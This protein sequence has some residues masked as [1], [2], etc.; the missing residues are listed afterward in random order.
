[1]FESINPDRGSAL[2]TF[3]SVIVITSVVLLAQLVTLNKS[4]LATMGHLAG[5][6]KLVQNK[7]KEAASQWDPRR[8]YKKGDL[9]VYSYPGFRQSVYMATTNSPEG[10]PFDLFLRATH[11]LFRHEL[12]HQSTSGI[13]ST[14]VTVHVAFMAV[15][16]CTILYYMAMG[17]SE[18]SLLT[19]LFANV[20]ACCGVLQ[21]G[22]I[23]YDELEGVAAELNMN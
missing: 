19:S 12:G 9:I 3:M 4:Y 21:T 17:Y 8:R 2:I 18:Q 16:S 23:G 10:R 13:I 7:R 15:I 14:A 6:W 11:D 5:E 22:L 1:M 20:V